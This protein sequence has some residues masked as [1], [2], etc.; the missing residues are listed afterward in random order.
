MPV[1]SCAAGYKR[2]V[3]NLQLK[4]LSALPSFGIWRI[5]KFQ[6]K[7]FWKKL[8][9][10]VLLCVFIQKKKFQAAFINLKYFNWRIHTSRTFTISK[11]LQMSVI[12][13]T[14]SYHKNILC[15]FLNRKAPK[16]LILTA[17][18]FLSCV[19][20]VHSRPV[21]PTKQNWRCSC[22]CFTNYMKILNA[23]V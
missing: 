4:L 8:L 2:Q 23:F 9:G 10:L 5:M 16:P 19:T 3:W 15:Y 14:V 17:L 22:L 7:N 20:C 12:K 13:K 6:K 11:H 1:I 21:V 18:Q